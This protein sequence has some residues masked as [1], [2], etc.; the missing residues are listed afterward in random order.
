MISRRTLLR[1]VGG[2][3]VVGAGAGLIR[4]ID[5][6]VIFAG[7]RPGLAAWNDWNHDRYSGPLA[8]VS[9]GILAS[10]P[11]N[12]QP[13]HFAVGRLGV[14]IFEAP[15][16]AL[17]AMDPFGR[18]RRLGLGAA[19]HNMA[20]ASTGIA[21]PATVRLLPD[22][23]DP[24]HVARI[25]LGPDG[26]AVA[27][28]PLLAA[29]GKRHTHRGGW[30]G[31]PVNA[32][33]RALLAQAGG[34]PDVRIALCDAGSAPGKR[35][36]ALTIDATQAITEDAAMMAASHRWF[37]HSRRDQDQ[38]KDGLGLV[39]SGVSPLLAAAAAMLPEQSAESEGRYWLAATRETAIPTA[40]LFGAILVGDPHDARSQLLA[41]AAWQRLH[42]IATARGLVA[43][44]LNQLPEIIDRD[45]Q[46][47]HRPRFT[48]TG[49]SDD[50]AWH[51]TFAFRI[52]HADAPALASPRR[53]V[54]EV[55]GPPS[56]LAWDVERARDETRAQDAA[57]ARKLR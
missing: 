33:D 12:T 38:L 16:R 15:E 57:L 44:P 41:G 10:S 20:L 22:P 53:P 35:F 23:G 2:L 34:S 56:R 6:G 55:I 39:T 5:Q 17:G 42:L 19:I 27:A 45:R 43:Q 9:A 37:H 49:L 28:H 40:S 1:G 36:G 51:P 50:P 21:R 7:D 4:A 14:D 18:E 30:T 31:A 52:G 11:H 46:L 26:L 13:W 24:L 29:I 32:M 25:E 3:G 47:G 48:A 8:L 54:S